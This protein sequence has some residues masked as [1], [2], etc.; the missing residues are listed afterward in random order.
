[1]I[2]LISVIVPIYNVERYLEQCVLSII[3][4]TYKNLQIILVDDGSEDNSGVLC[5]ELKKRDGRIDV[6]H[7]QNGG[8]VSAR[9]AGLRMAKG[10]YI[11]FVD[12]DDY[13]NIDMYENLM[14]RILRTNA[15]FIHFGYFRE[16]TAISQLDDDVI[17]IQKNKS[18]FINQYI[19]SG[20]SQKRIAYSIWS[21]FFKAEF[22]RECYFEVPDDI[23]FGEDLVSL[24]ICVLKGKRIALMNSSYYHYTIRETSISHKRKDTA[25]L[26]AVRLFQTIEMILKKYEQYD[27]IKDIL[28]K[29]WLREVICERLLMTGQNEF[30]R[31]YYR[32]SDISK[33]FGKKI[34]VYGA[35]QVGRDYYSQICRY[36]KCK[37]V[38]WVDRNYKNI[39][40]DCIDIGGINQLKNLEFDILLIAIRYENDA[41]KVKC[42]LINDEGISEEKIIWIKPS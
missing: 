15:D 29:E 5:D 13:I 25:L 16:N 33:L 8:L 19:I 11:A 22:I 23:L 9:K 4:Q 12:G 21:K 6:I 34:V 30:Q 20:K 32:I 35:G 38:S 39:Q 42:N 2:P 27:G 18:E 41:Q 37:I 28:I 24:I 1:M 14:K 3:Q 10:Q 7:K 40:Y 31:E 26:D 36:S 17:E